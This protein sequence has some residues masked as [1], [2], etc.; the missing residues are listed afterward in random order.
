MLRLY[1]GLLQK[2]LAVRSAAASQEWVVAQVVGVVEED[3]PNLP[4]CQTLSW[5]AP[6]LCAP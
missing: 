5:D 4:H 1:Y 6:E 3:C 2:D